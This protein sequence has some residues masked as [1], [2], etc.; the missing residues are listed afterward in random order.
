MGPGPVISQA[1]MRTWFH[2]P[3]RTSRAA[4]P[5]VFWPLPWLHHRQQLG[6][7]RRTDGSRM[8]THRGLA[9]SPSAIFVTQLFVDK[10]AANHGSRPPL[11]GEVG[12]VGQTAHLTRASPG[13]RTRGVSPR[14]RNPGD[15]GVCSLWDVAEVRLWF[16]LLSTA[17]DRFYHR[18]RLCGL[19]KL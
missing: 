4:S 8:T 15:D 6:R 10:P 14:R 11:T 12:N 17:L 1:L 5:Q 19:L 2:Q 9:F 3:S 13:N 16:D 18:Q 7:S